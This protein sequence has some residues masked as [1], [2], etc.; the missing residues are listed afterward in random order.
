MFTFPS[1][2]ILNFMS[3]AFKYPSGAFSSCNVY[4]SSSF[5]TPYS[6]SAFSLDVNSF[7]TFPS[8]SM[9]CNNAP[10]ILFP[11]SSVFSILNSVLSS[12]ISTSNSS[13]VSPTVNS[14]STFL[15]YRFGAFAS[16]R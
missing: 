9:I 12:D 8:S 2:S 1:S 16:C 5:N 13:S 3:F 14:T 10:D 7:T 4:I 6:S 11:F 15:C